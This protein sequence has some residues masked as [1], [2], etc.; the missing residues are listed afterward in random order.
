MVH[1]KK[2]FCKIDAASTFFFFFFFLIVAASTFTAVLV[3][4]S[5]SIAFASETDMYT[6][7]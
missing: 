1:L 4:R 5:N 7:Q 2:M 6:S 3:I